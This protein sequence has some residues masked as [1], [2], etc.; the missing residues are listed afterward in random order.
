MNSGFIK[1]E[2]LGNDEIPFNSYE[3]ELPNLDI[4]FAELKLSQALDNYAN[5]KFIHDSPISI[6][7]GI[8]TFEAVDYNFKDSSEM[9]KLALTKILGCLINDLSLALLADLQHAELLSWAAFG[10][11]LQTLWAL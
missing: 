3:K 4:K 9:V 11:T 10:P 1:F 8:T 2:L 5:T 7:F 6:T